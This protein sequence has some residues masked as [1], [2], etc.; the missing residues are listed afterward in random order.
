M[1]MWRFAEATDIPCSAHLRPLLGFYGTVFDGIVS[2]CVNICTRVVTIWSS[3]EGLHINVN[4]NQFGTF[5]LSRYWLMN[6]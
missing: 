4:V 2:P 1:S 5:R 6:E 3:I